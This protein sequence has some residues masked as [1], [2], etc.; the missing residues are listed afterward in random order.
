MIPTAA[1]RQ[2]LGV[3]YL[4]HEVQIGEYFRL[5]VCRPRYFNFSAIVFYASVIGIMIVRGFD[6][7]SLWRKV[8]VTMGLNCRTLR[9]YRLHYNLLLCSTKF[10]A[11]AGGH[12][13]VPMNICQNIHMIFYF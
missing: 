12:A 5:P 10:R 7:N 8:N 3:E 11:K 4:F 1:S 9:V 13:S 2:Q 6:S